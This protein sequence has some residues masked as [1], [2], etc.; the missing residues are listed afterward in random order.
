MQ[1]LLCISTSHLRLQLQKHVR[2]THNQRLVQLFRTLPSL[3][4]EAEHI[5]ESYRDVDPVV[6]HTG[7]GRRGLGDRV[8]LLVEWDAVLY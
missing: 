1:I 2:S 5:G 4:A 6:D 7:G 8:W 3:V